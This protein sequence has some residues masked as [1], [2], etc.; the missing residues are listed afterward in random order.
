[1]DAALRPKGTF[2]TK[3]RPLDEQVRIL[4]DAIPDLAMPD[5]GFASRCV[6][7][8]EADGWFAI[9]SFKAGANCATFLRQFTTGRFAEL[10]PFRN[11]I[12][13][14]TDPSRYVYG[15]FGNILRAATRSMQDESDIILFPGTFGDRHPE[16]C[17][18]F[19]RRFRLKQDEFLLGVPDVLSLLLTHP[20][21]L[22]AMGAPAMVAGAD[23]VR[24]PQGCGATK[25]PVLSAAYFGTLLTAIG[26]TETGTCISTPSGF[27]PIYADLVDGVIA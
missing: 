23:M 27:A 22:G 14:L 5:L 24:Q 4:R 10:V 2:S 6:T 7:P 9:I 15:G 3:I 16:R 20:E 26:E 18:A 19:T 13:D 8:P 25:V 1:M 11:D 17:V 12:G 21:R